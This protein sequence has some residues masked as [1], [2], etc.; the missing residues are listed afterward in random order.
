MP[1]KQQKTGYAPNGYGKHDVSDKNC[2][3]DI[4][5]NGKTVNDFVDDTIKELG[6]KDSEEP[7][8][9]ASLDSLYVRHLMWVTKLPRVKPFY[10][11]KCNNTPAVLKMLR[12]LGTGFDCSSKNEMEL[13]LSLGVSP[14][15][16]I[17]AHTTK[18]MSHLRYAYAHGVNTMTFDNEE[19]LQKISFCHSKA[20]LVLR[21]AVDDSK[22]AFKL[23]LKFGAKMERVCQLL[24][25][26]KELDLKVIGVSFHVG[27][28]CTDSRAFKQ[29]IADARQAFDIATLL[30]FQMS[31]LDIGGGYSGRNDY[32]V[33]FEKFA[34][35]INAAL[36]EFFP[37]DG[38]VKV[39]AEPGRYYVESAFTLAVNIIAKK[40]ITDSEDEHREGVETPNKLMVYYIND[41]VYGS[42]NCLLNDPTHTELEIQPHRDV[43]SC[44]QR[45]RTVIWG[46]TC[47]ST[48]K[49]SDSSCF[50]EMNIGD[51]FLIDNMGAYSV[52]ISSGF[53]GFER[54]HVYSVV[55]AETW[56]SL[57]YSD[58]L[59][60]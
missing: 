2:D 18:P 46:P 11:V 42:L 29:A 56:H 35:D 8:F 48:D 38:R 1:N 32:Q 28:G 39:I 58:K 24:E 47:D 31:L 16:V 51:W 53:N 34:E 27:S 36:E 50:P 26:A 17:Y 41:G 59:F 19:E 25:H 37:S 43:D 3:I 12:A 30:G 21:I 10:A 6:S 54:P 23:S 33:T 40:V 15:D 60:F 44:E 13:A 4:L 49:I 57:N 5:D 22:S 14:N 55:T 20:K 45:Y 7:F 52:S 9:V